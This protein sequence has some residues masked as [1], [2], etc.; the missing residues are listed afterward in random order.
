MLVE[1]GRY[2]I[3][4]AAATVVNVGVFALLR[5]T[6]AFSI[7][8]AS[9][10]AWILSVLAA[11]LLNRFF[12]FRSNATEAAGAISQAHKKRSG[13]LVELAEFFAA[14]VFTGGMDVALTFLGAEILL[15]HEL[16]VKIA[17][18]ALVVACNYLVA[19]FWIFKS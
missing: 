3:A 4:G 9:T 18:N 15:L 19:K 6:H 1:G 8:C 2:V 7:L 5:R 16:G 11:F 14:R 12:V 17:V 13:G 10:A